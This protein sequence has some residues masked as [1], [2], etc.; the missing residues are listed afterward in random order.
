MNYGERLRAI[1]DGKAAEMARIKELKQQREQERINQLMADF[2]K[3]MSSHCERALL[4][5]D[6]GNPPQVTKLSGKFLDYNVNPASPQN[7]K[8]VLNP[9]FLQYRDR[10]LALGL[11][12]YIQYVNDGMGVASWYN[13][14]VEPVPDIPY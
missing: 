5:I 11:R 14:V 8:H 3:E 9:V 7:P 1:L 2:H 6:S 4:A 12:L 13:L 10:F